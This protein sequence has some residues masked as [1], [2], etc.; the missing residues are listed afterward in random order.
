MAR[1]LINLV[2]L[3]GGCSGEHEVSLLSTKSIVKAIDKSKYKLILI[4]ISKEG[5]WFRFDEQIF[6]NG[7]TALLTNEI[8]NDYDRVI[9][10]PENGSTYLYNITKWQKEDEIDVLFPVLHGPNGE[11][12]TVQGLLK[13][14][15]LPFVG[16]GVLGS[17]LAMDKDASKRM[18]QEADI[19]VARWI[20]V[21][22]T[23]NLDFLSITKQLGSPIFIKPAN[24]G[25]S[26]GISKVENEKDF[27]TGLKK[28]FSFDNRVI[29]EEFIDARE[30]ECSV[31]GNNN[32]KASLPGEIV[33]KHKFYSY[34]AKYVDKDGAELIIPAK[35]KEKTISSIQTMAMDTF[36]TLYCEGMARVDFFL[37]KNGQL[38]V[39]EINTIPGFTSISMYPKLWQV[40]GLEFSKLIDDLINL[41]FER[42]NKKK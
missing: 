34:H 25:S 37:L 13:L 7:K 15:N 30:I 26:V 20:T 19:P 3:F 17:A 14:F 24:L 5:D 40:S 38:I 28:A 1:H 39:N 18:L 36:K 21:M 10:A 9:L 4:G 41:A 8:Q 16:A 11:D 33:T 6:S 42:H 35:L 22:N 32:P 29:I 31:I 12:G 27:K 23:D 2:L